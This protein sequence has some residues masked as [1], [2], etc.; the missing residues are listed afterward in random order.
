METTP[1]VIALDMD[2]CLVSIQ[3]KVIEHWQAHG[4]SHEYEDVTTFEY[5]DTL[6]E[7]AH[8]LAWEVIHRGDLY[9]DLDPE[10]GALEAVRQL[11]LQGHRVIVLSSPAHGH[12]GSKLRWLERHG[13]PRGD[14]VLAKDKVLAGRAADVLVDDS[15]ANLERW[16]RAGKVAVAYERPWNRQH[17]WP[18]DTGAPLSVPSWNAAA[19]LIGWVCLDLDEAATTPGEDRSA[20]EEALELVVADRMSD[21]GH[22]ASNFDAIADVWTGLLQPHLRPGARLPGAVVP[23]LMIGL[24]ACREMTGRPKRDNRV[25]VAGYLRALELARERWDEGVDE[26]G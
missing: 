11:Q 16:M 17:P 2:G 25:D 14:V 23:W 20:L 7:E 18:E 26:R 22:P 24:K 4:L 12:A 9:D 5:R 3:G 13:F 6:G 10:P 19:Q 1:K 21:Y 15:P 8:D